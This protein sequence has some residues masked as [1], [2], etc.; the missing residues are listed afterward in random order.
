MSYESHESVPPRS[1]N[2]WM[3]AACDGLDQFQREEQ[4]RF[5]C[6]KMVEKAFAERDSSR[7]QALIARFEMAIQAHDACL[8][9]NT[10]AFAA[11]SEISGTACEAPALRHSHMA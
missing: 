6:D 10:A 7:L 11:L 3:D 8:A 9:A 2:E 1:F 5:L 4:N